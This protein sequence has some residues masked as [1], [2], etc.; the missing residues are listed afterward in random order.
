PTGAALLVELVDQ[1]GP[2][3]PM[4]IDSV[5]MGAGTKDSAHVANVL[6]LIVG[7]ADSG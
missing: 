2:M 7:Q 4:T 5:G 6:R 1:W 3:P